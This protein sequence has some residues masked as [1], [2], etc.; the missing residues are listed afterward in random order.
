MVD[1]PLVTSPSMKEGCVYVPFFYA[2]VALLFVSILYLH[3]LT[4]D[5][6]LFATSLFPLGPHPPL[7]IVFEPTI[8]FSSSSIHLD[9]HISTNSNLEAMT[10]TTP[11]FVLQ[12]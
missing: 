5:Q 10:D 1:P 2:S 12:P 7:F 11:G 6:F 3:T 8:L 9:S 4:T